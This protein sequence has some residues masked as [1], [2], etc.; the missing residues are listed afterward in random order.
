MPGTAP[1]AAPPA[2]VKTVSGK[3]ITIALV[4][5]ALILSAVVAKVRTDNW[6]ER[7]AYQAGMR[8]AGYVMLS[9]GN[10]ITD[11]GP[12]TPPPVEEIDAGVV[13]DA[14]APAPVPAVLDAGPVEVVVK[15]KAPPTPA[16]ETVLASMA[17]LQNQAK[18]ETLWE[19][20]G[21]IRTKLQTPSAR[22][23]GLS[24]IIDAACARMDNASLK[25]IVGEY[26]TV[27][28]TAQVRAARQ[29]C[30]KFYP[31]SEFLDW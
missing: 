4:S 28:T 6:K 12:K 26:R 8:D 10:F 7:A 23:R 14:G 24:I 13:I 22:E 20:R 19:A 30:I 21:Q 16:E 18:W 29:R 11:A 1:S 25:P 27:A 17:L 15:T 3:K 31:S 2:P 9:D 5:G